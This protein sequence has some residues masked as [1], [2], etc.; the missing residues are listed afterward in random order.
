MISIIFIMFVIM[1]IIIISSSSIVIIV[2][3][4]RLPAF[5]A[6]PERPER[7]RPGVQDHPAQ[8]QKAN[9]GTLTLRIIP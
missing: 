4:H 3:L 2:R 7:G 6:G 1:I 9:K 8:D 5:G